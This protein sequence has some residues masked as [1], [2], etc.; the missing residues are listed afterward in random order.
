MKLVLDICASE[1]GIG[2]LLSASLCPPMPN[3]VKSWDFRCNR[4]IGFNWNWDFG[5]NRKT[6]FS[7]KI[8]LNR[9]IVA[10]TSRISDGIAKQ[11]FDGSDSELRSMKEHNGD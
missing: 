4:K 9:K 5:L 11:W 6:G 3:V 1:V 8:G 2:Q 7:R 10:I